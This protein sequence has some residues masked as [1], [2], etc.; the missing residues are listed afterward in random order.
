MLLKRISGL[1]SRAMDRNLPADSQGAWVR[2]L[3]QE[4]SICCGGLSPGTT[5]TDLHSRAC[6]PKRR[7]PCVLSIEAP[8]PG[9]CTSQEK[10]AHHN[11]EQLPLSVTKAHTKQLGPG[12]PKRK[13]RGLQCLEDYS[14]IST[15]AKLFLKICREI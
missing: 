8:E 1:P 4:D 11:R 9:A 13:S 15:N 6:E 7:S 3:V 14:E 5:P 2:S 10:P 12:R